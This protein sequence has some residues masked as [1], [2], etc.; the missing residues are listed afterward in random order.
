M[1]VNSK[2]SLRRPL[3]THAEVLAEAAAYHDY[4]KTNSIP[5]LQRVLEMSE[6]VMSKMEELYSHNVKILEILNHFGME[7]KSLAVMEHLGW[8]NQQLENVETDLICNRDTMS[9]LEDVLAQLACVLEFEAARVA[10]LGFSFRVDV[11]DDDLP[12]GLR[13]TAY[14]QWE[15]RRVHRVVT[16]SFERECDILMRILLEDAPL[17]FLEREEEPEIARAGLETYHN[18]KNKFRA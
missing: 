8:M 3:G 4:L 13:A 14:A 7:E 5:T 12:P 15:A 11:G 17:D 10:G 18:M 6:E 2:P 1:P 9:N 16:H